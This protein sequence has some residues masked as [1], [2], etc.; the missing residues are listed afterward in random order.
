MYQDK[1]GNDTTRSSSAKARQ[2]K[3]TAARRNYCSEN[4]QT[5][6]QIV[7]RLE[8]L[9]LLIGKGKANEVNT[10]IRGPPPTAVVQL[11]DL[12][13]KNFTNETMDKPSSPK[14]R[15]P[16]LETSQMKQEIED[17]D[18]KEPPPPKV[19]SNNCNCTII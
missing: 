5:I 10:L 9:E 12:S 18:F 13:K 8:Q 7:R 6:E 15:T 14:L 11:E 4:L 1:K 16:L 19:I 17:G 2:Q 3:K